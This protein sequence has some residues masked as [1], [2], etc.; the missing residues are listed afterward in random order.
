VY[1]YDSMCSCTTFSLFK[2]LLPGF[3]QS[4]VGP[5]L[6]REN[7]WECTLMLLD[8]HCTNLFESGVILKSCDFFVCQSVKNENFRYTGA[9]LCAFLS[10]NLL[11]HS[12]SFWKM[13][14]QRYLAFYVA[15]MPLLLKL[16]VMI[17]LCLVCIFSYVLR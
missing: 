10:Q 11:H 5:Q 4:W 1:C 13:L 8:G 7:H 2:W 16:P 9:R 3:F 12:V 17:I 15:A 6:Q 14:L